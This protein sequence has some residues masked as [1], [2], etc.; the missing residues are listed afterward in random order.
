MS[1]APDALLTRGAPAARPD[2]TGAPTG[3]PRRLVE[4]VRRR[5]LAVLMALALLAAGVVGVL[6]RGTGVHRRLLDKGVLS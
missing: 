5:L 4:G 6:W 2:R 3:L 1:I